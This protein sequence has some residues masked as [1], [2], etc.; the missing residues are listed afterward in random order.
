MQVCDMVA[1]LPIYTMY[2][3]IDSQTHICAHLDLE[4]LAFLCDLGHRLTQRG[5]QSAIMAALGGVL[6]NIRCC[7]PSTSVI[8]NPS[9]QPKQLCLFQSCD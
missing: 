2:A 4:V 8:T 9:E 7:D 1:K 3:L 5:P 6:S